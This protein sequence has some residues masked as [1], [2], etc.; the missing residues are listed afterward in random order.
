MPQATRSADVVVIGAGVIGLS[1]ALELRRA[2]L[3]VTVIERGSVGR[4]AASWAGGG[5]L[6]P[7]EPDGVDDATM[8]LLH[9]SLAG[10][11]PWC[12]DLQSASGI[13]PEYLVSGLQVLPPADLDAWTVAAR[14]WTLASRVVTRRSGG[15]GGPVVELPG[16]AQVRS[17][18]LLRALLH[19]F[20]AA[21]GICL[22]GVTG[23]SLQGESHVCGVVTDQGA[24]AA[25][26]VVMAAGAWSN[27][28]G[29]SVPVR[30]VRGQMLLMDAKPG[31]LRSIVLREGRYLV[32]RRDGVVLVG[33]TLE[34]A[35]FVDQTTDEAR[36]SLLASLRDLAPSLADRRVLAHWSGL[37]PAPT[38][39]APLIGWHPERQGLYLNTGHHRLGITLAPGS[40]RRAAQQILQMRTG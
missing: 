33:S 10:Y 16:V 24:V 8:P 23:V 17:P 13:D 31:E 20:R 34:E 14:R 1:T 37:R 3:R 40:A 38:G 22:E 6:S 39:S 12:A 36:V 25:G 9:D 27:G 18:R 19:A 4:G 5:I 32:P 21:G 26:I 30:P 28:W 29:A 2:G 15:D 11:R 35:G 7:L